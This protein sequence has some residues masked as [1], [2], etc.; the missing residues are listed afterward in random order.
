MLQTT[1]VRDRR[2]TRLPLV[3]IIIAML[4]GCAGQ[5][6]VPD[7]DWTHHGGDAR[8][9][10]HSPLAAIDTTNVAQLRV[11][12]RWR[13]P[14][15]SLREAHP[16]L[17]APFLHEV[18]PLAID[19]VLYVSTS[20]S[21][22]VAID[23]LTGRTLWTF[24]PGA[25]KRSAFRPTA[26]GDD[27]GIPATWGFVHRG[28]AYWRDGTAARVFLATGDAFLYS[29][30]AATGRPDSAFGDGGTVDL[31]VGLSRPV[32]RP[33]HG[34]LDYGVSSPPIVCGGV[35][36]VGS[37]IS[38]DTPRPGG[39][40]GDVRGYDPRT[41]AQRWRFHTIP[42]DGE[43]GAET[44]H[45][46]LARREYAH[47]N[48]WSLMSCDPELG[49][50]YLPVGA[51]ANDYYGGS[52]AGDNLFSESIVAL[53]ARTGRRVWHF[54]TAHHGLWDYDPPAAP[55]LGDITVDG[56]VVK[57]AIAVTKQGFVFV[58]DRVTGE[59]VWPIEERPVPAAGAVPGERPSPTQPFPTRPAPFERQGVVAENLIDLTP[60]LQREA[61]AMLRRYH[62]GP[63]Y[64]PPS[65]RGTLV[66]PGRT[67][68]ANWGGAAFDPA[69]GVLYVPSQTMVDL[70]RLAPASAQA[71]FRY[72]RE[73]AAYAEGPRGLPLVKPP[74]G[75]LTA[76]GLSQE[77]RH[78]WMTPVGDGPWS[79]PALRV[80]E[81]APLGS[82]R[83][84]FAIVTAGGLLFVTEGR[85]PGRETA[86]WRYKSA[87][88]QEE[89][90]RSW[91]RAFA[92]SD[93]RLLW[94]H[95]LP[96]PGSALPMTFS[97]GGRQLL[98]LAVGGMG[99]WPQE[100]VA[101]ALTDDEGAE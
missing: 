13:S 69:I 25:W 2:Q 45:D 8:S 7:Q 94:E 101:F 9:T 5:D 42:R 80:L 31:T 51:A 82:P 85:A 24:D 55:V 66:L 39:P 91:L 37:N 53:D 78:L 65:E 30:D 40:P 73:G 50:V 32:V 60:E 61:A 16:A 34:K 68:G 4:T 71:P 17:A 98:V 56:R 70:Y 57:A 93:G 35:L 41:G 81:P 38:D 74:W 27:A 33:E 43:P 12:W 11:V 52:R 84:R 59:P 75:R 83:F 88:M 6:L 48:V 79:H 21:L 49:Y 89:L 36:V 29:L 26:A 62:H 3:A 90:E 47:A 10:K 97:R 58:L 23:G 1:P 92:A 63:L 96:G 76:I 18:T 100:L 20:Y 67:G 95:E 77:G 86:W 99:F 64:T 44:W 87:T 72:Y 15:D 14:D 54:Q 22:A 46:A 28:V 19:G